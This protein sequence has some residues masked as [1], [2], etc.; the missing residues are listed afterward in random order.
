MILAITGNTTLLTQIRLYIYWM[1]DD[2]L[3]HENAM[4]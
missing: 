3:S 4:K 1:E 2:R